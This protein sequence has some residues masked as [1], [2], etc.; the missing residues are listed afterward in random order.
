MNPSGTEIKFNN[1]Y[2]NGLI[3]VFMA[4]GLW[5]TVGLGIRL[6]EEASVWQILFYRSLSLSCLLFGVIYLRSGNPLK[7]I[8]KAGVPAAVAGISL[9]LAYSGGVYSIQSTS[10]ANAML[11]FATAPLFTAIF[12][13]VFLKEKVT[14]STFVAIIIAI[15]GICIMISDKMNGTELWGS[16]AAIG[17]AIGFAVFTVALRWGKSR[18]MLPAVLLSGIFGII[19]TGG[20]CLTLKLSFN[21]I[22]N[23]L[24]IAFG[25]GIFQVGA[26]LVLYTLGS[27]YLPATQLALLSLTEVLLGPFWVWL[28]LGE[29]ASATTLYGGMVLLAAIAFNAFFENNNSAFN[30]S[31]YWNK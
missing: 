9:V 8:H 7:L 23:D 19:I 13:L 27:K 6:I 21:L 24:S 4:G 25:M 5:S 28:V 14:G 12:S 17:S 11:L 10:V 30:K 16:L 2:L 26:G 29:T 18:D 22:S 20:I 3:S 15:L 31:S 1:S